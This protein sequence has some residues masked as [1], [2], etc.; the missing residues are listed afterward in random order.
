MS[1]QED[2][3]ERHQN[4]YRRYRQLEQKYIREKS[5]RVRLQE[6]NIRLKEQVDQL[7]TGLQ[8]LLRGKSNLSTVV[9]MMVMEMAE[10][11]SGIMNA[12]K[13]LRKHVIP[14]EKIIIPIG[15]LVIAGLILSKPE[16]VD[17][18]VFW[19]SQPMNQMF[20]LS[21]TGILALFMYYYSKRRTAK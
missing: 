10:A 20:T 9:A 8:G 17:R 11:Q 13:S 2:V 12:Y 7:M 16:Y 6:E 15:I 19:L 4:L 14:W 18:I 3:Y 21:F 1:D 5:E